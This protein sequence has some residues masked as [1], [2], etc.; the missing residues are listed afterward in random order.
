ML[1]IAAVFQFFGIGLLQARLVMVLYLAAAG[2]I[3]FVLAPPPP[4]HALRG[5]PWRC[6]SPR[7]P[8][9]WSSLAA[10]CWAKCRGWP[11]WPAVFYC[12]SFAGARRWWELVL[13]GL[14]FGLSVVTK[15]QYLLVLGGTLL[16]AWGLNLLF[17]AAAA[18]FPHPRHRDRCGLRSLAVV[19]AGLPGPGDD[20]RE[21]ASCG[22]SHA[23]AAAVFSTDLML[24]L[25]GELFS[26]KA[27]LWMLFPALLYSGWW[28]IRPQHDADAAVTDRRHQ[29]AIL[30]VLV[31]V[32]LVGGMSWP[33]ELAALMPSWGWPS[34]LFVSLAFAELTD[35]FSR[36]AAVARTARRTVAARGWRP[37]AARARSNDCCVRCELAVRIATAPPDD[38]RKWRSAWMPPCRKLRWSK[39]GSRRWGSSPTT[40]IIIRRSCC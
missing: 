33:G 40:A 21:P 17:F 12:G 27:F 19:H 32:N 5:L 13:V 29:L 38:S 9:T 16:L 7:R 3:F 6:S 14:L 8:S 36:H 22:R 30:Y 25:L 31:V 37:P 18:P 11:S 23:G 2:A 1:P 35:D 39:H 15:Y 10:R 26:Q 34:T 28:L 20:R 24:R 4:G